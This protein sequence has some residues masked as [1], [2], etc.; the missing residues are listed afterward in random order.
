MLILAISLGSGLGA[1][2]VPEVFSNMPQLIKDIGHSS[3]A[4]GGMSAILAT[5]VLSFG[6][7]QE[8]EISE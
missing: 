2:F 4:V 6:G 7:Q 5:L 1:H 8:K 3:I